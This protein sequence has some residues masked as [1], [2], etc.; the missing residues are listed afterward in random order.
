MVKELK[1]FSFYILHSHSI[2]ST[3]DVAV[4]SVLTQQDVDCNTK[5][6]WIAKTQEY[7]IEIKPTKLIRGNSLCNVIVENKVNKE[8]EES[9]EKQLVLAIG[10]YESW[11]EN[12]SYFLTYGECP[13]GINAK[14]KR[15]L[16]LKVAK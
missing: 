7:D 9:K 13:E 8:S 1:N 14:Q 5:G 12:M 3:P 15:D 10:L 6:A 16:K 4:K 2:V 11:F